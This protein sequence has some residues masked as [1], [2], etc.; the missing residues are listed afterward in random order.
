MVQRIETIEYGDLPLSLGASAVLNAELPLAVAAHI[1]RGQWGHLVARS[2][3]ESNT[4]GMWCRAV[5]IMFPIKRIWG[6]DIELQLNARLSGFVRLDA[7]LDGKRGGAN[8]L[9]LGYFD[10]PAADWLIAKKPQLSKVFG[11][12][13]D[14]NV[15]PGDC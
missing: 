1:K 6:F 7:A 13:I 4:L 9:E 3:C 8:M 12:R 14:V 15:L 10:R 11:H 5:S 2:D